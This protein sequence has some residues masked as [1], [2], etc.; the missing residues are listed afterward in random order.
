MLDAPSLQTSKVRLDGALSTDGGRGEEEEE[1][2]EGSHPSRR[3]LAVPR[4]GSRRLPMAAV[5]PDLRRQWVE[6]SLRASD[7]WKE[8]GI[9]LT[10][11]ARSCREKDAAVVMV[12]TGGNGLKLCHGK[13]RLEMRENFS[14]KR[15]VTRWHSC[16]GSG[17]VTHCP[18]RCSV[19]RCG[20]E[21]CGDW[22]RWD[23]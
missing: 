11:S 7:R 18:W 8:I 14:S 13:F 2:E 10:P 17:G 20:T 15:G 19:W 23:G 16:P 1:E 12:R 21:G 22:A 5:G 6:A 4:G 3:F 9:K